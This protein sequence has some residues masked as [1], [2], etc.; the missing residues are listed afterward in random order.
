[1]LQTLATS[2][3]ALCIVFGLVCA[4]IGAMCHKVVAL[5]L[6]NPKTAP[7]API[8][9]DAGNAL[10]DAVKTAEKDLAAGKSAAAILTDLL[11]GLKADAAKAVPDVQKAISGEVAALQAKVAVP[12]PSP[13]TAVKDVPPFAP[14]NAGVIPLLIV[15]LIAGGIALAGGIAALILTGNGSQAASCVEGASSSNPTAVGALVQALATGDAAGVEAALA[16]LG[17]T[18]AQCVL[19]DLWDDAKAKLALTA[20]QK[21]N[22][23]L[24]AVTV[25]QVVNGA[26][27]ECVKRGWYPKGTVT[28]AQSGT[29][30]TST[31]NGK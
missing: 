8:A 28:T 4:G 2:P 15:V 7:L 22:P 21:A 30:G 29:V 11:A 9:Q 19:T 5:L 31:S 1:M 17:P 20:A 26:Q 6:A 13:L 3:V 24:T 27:V 14:K 18:I 16:S 23:A 10:D 25:A 12:L